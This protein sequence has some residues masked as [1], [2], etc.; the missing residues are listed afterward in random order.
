MENLKQLLKDGII[1][2]EEFEII[3]KRYEVSNVDYEEKW[4]DILNDFYNWCYNKY[5]VSTSKGYK[6]CLYKFIVYLTKESDNQEAMQHKF[7]IYSFRQ[8]N[9]FINK[10]QEDGLGNQAISKTK[11]ALVV[12]GNY[13]KTKGV[14]VPD[15]SKIKISI[16]DDVNT[17]SIAL[18][19]DEVIGI[20]TVGDLRSE[21]CI[22][23]C[24][25][26]ALKRIELSNLKVSDFDFNKNQMFIRNNEEKIDRVCI[27]SN[28]TIK[29]LK[30]YIDEL[31][32]NIERWNISR[33]SKGKEPREDFGYI[34]QS[35]KMTVPSYALLQT[36]LKENTK[37]YYL[38]QNLSE[39]KYNK[40]ISNVTFES[41]RNSR[42]VYLLSIGVDIREVM[43]MCGDK[44][45]MSTYR[46]VKLVPMLYPET[47]DMR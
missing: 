47:I 23:L 9:S 13:L 39:E 43:Q 20:A 26:G 33:V 11:Y 45:Y 1:T 5:S 37:N 40:S 31:Y 22:R 36:M 24:Y 34:F 30:E 41:I 21:V 18:K 44:N 27:L 6:I 29:L 28:K 7:E 3:S 38:K 2:K 16:K 14:E 19:Q 17:T 15:I 35:V 42:K 32:Y 12:L 8:V 4:G 25:E 46:F 10:L